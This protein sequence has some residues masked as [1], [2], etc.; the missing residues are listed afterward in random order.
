M[1]MWT[2]PVGPFQMNTYVLWEEDSKAAM[3]ID[4][5]DEISKIRDVIKKEGLKVERIVLTHG[6]I[7]HVAHAETLHQELKVPM[8]L[9]KDDWDMAAAT[10]Q[11]ALMFGLPPGPTPQIDGE[12]VEGENVGFGAVEFDIVHTPGHSPGS[13]T[14]V[15]PELA[16]VGDVIFAGSIGRTDLPGGNMRVLQSTIMQKIVTLD[17]KLALYPGHGP[18]TTVENELRTNPFVLEWQ[19]MAR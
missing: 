12:L 2:R 6:H 18:P 4:P 10:P 17:P 11:Q 19:A 5:G 13:V 15:H 9:H 8:L 16:I 3:V 1:K 14:L 7:D